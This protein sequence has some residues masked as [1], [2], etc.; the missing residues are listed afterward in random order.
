MSGEIK[1][2]VS[3]VT[4]TKNGN[5]IYV[6]FEDKDRRAELVLPEYALVKNTGFSSEEISAL[7]DYMDKEKESI[8]R[9]AKNV[10]IMDAF[11][12]KK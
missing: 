5:A 8:Y 4:Q 6:M 9:L 12:K 3:S 2:S 1:M 11:M 10:G 7:K